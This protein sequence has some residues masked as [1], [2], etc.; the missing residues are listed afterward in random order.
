MRIVLCGARAIAAACARAS[1]HA[2][3]LLPFPR[4]DKRSDPRAPQDSFPARALPAPVSR[5]AAWRGGDVRGAALVYTMGWAGSV[6]DVV[7]VAVGGEAVVPRRA[8]Q[9]RRVPLQERLV[10]GVEDALLA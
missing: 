3:A 6:R 9:G 2:R 7:E 1:V 4:V 10:D 8:R 5:A